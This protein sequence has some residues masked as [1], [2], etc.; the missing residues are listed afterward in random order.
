MIHASLQ[1]ISILSD[2]SIV[3]GKSFLDV[4]NMSLMLWLIVALHSPVKSWTHRSE[5]SEERWNREQR[6]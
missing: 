3:N 2:V 6:K 4:L 5:A 1:A